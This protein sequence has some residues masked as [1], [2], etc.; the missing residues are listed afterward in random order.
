M[1]YLNIL[2]GGVKMD[3]LQQ[4]LQANEQ[5]TG[6]FS[7]KNGGT[8][9]EVTKLPSRRLAVF[10][11]MDTRLVDFLE[12]AFGIGRGEAKVIK[13]AGNSLVGSFESVIGSLLIS[14]F[15][16]EVK[17]ILVVGHLDCGV[18]NVESGTLIHKMLDR[19]IPPEAIKIIERELVDWIDHFYD[20]VDNIQ[21]VTFKI[22]SNPLIPH[23]IPVHG[24]LIDPQTG[25][26]SVIVNGYNF[27]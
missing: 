23:D 13:N 20:P 2:L 10:T 25:K 19:G 4:I 22:R 24:L 8:F 5:F 21:K 14:I 6:N 16:L 26:L 1:L 9:P 15:E 18:A 11:C 17:E 7:A 27:L 3:T 12:P